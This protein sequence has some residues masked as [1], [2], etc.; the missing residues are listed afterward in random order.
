MSERTTQLVTGLAFACLM[1]AIGY[2]TILRGRTYALEKG[3]HIPLLLESAEGLRVGAPVLV[4][5]IEMGVVSSLHYVLTR[6]DGS[7]LPWKEEEAARR[8]PG[9]QKVICILDLIRDVPL[10]PNYKI[11]S[12]YPSPISQKIVAI[13]PGRLDAKRPDWQPLKLSHEQLLAFRA[14]GLFPNGRDM[15]SSANSDDPIYLAA[16]VINDNRGSLFRITSNLAEITR[17]I[18]EGNGT[19]A[20]ALNRDVLSA[21]A[22]RSLGGLIIF[23]NEIRN[24]VEDTRESRG[25]TDL[26]AALLPV[27]FYAAGF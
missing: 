1:L 19:L 23:L 16:S 15:L 17:K 11:T 22:N 9:G 26:I 5:G 24:G 20:A 13:D 27:F 10:Y 2:F 18:N 8:S 25:M 21:E 14:T 3:V 6:E 12:R 4:L 7:I